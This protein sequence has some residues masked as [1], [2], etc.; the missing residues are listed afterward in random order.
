MLNDE[1]VLTTKPTD[2]VRTQKIVTLQPAKNENVVLKDKIGYRNVPEHDDISYIPVI[3]IPATMGSTL[4]S[5]LSKYDKSGEIIDQSREFWPT[6]RKDKQAL[7]W[8]I[9]EN[10]KAEKLVDVYDDMIEYL[11]GRSFSKGDRKYEIKLRTFP[12]DWRLSASAVTHA[13]ELKR[14]IELEYGNEK[15]RTQDFQGVIIIA[16]SLGGLVLRNCIMEDHT[17]IDKIDK[18]FFLGT[19]HKGSTNMFTTLIWGI[20]IL[21]TDVFGI[22]G[23]DVIHSEFMKQ[24]SRAMESAY[25]MLPTYDFIIYENKNKPNFELYNWLKN[26]LEIG[27]DPE[28]YNKAKSWHEKLDSF[29]LNNKIRLEIKTYIAFAASKNTY[30]NIQVSL[31]GNNQ[32]ILENA[33]Y[34]LG[35][36]TV[37]ATS[38]TDIDNIQKQCFD[39]K[40]MDLVSEEVAEW[41]FQIIIR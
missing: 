36:E 3:L 8:T 41:I 31:S 7:L 40:H 28:K 20:P 1:K 37:L 14:V 39:L 4:V 22:D 16:H 2:E 34:D 10:H 29:Y 18:M 13:T 15:K 5:S 23:L 26:D 24:I 32:L 27:V 30:E 35:D 17:L 38:A 6:I 19:P 25:D 11:S 33:S 12:Y 21:E 9:Q